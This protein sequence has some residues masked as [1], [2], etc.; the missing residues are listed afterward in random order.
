[1]TAVWVEFFRSICNRAVLI[2]GCI[3]DEKITTHGAIEEHL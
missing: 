1:M 3:G 2:D